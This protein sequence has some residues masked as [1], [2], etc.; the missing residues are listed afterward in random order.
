VTPFRRRRR[1]VRSLREQ[2]LSDP[3]FVRHQIV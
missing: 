3:L 2:I 1:T